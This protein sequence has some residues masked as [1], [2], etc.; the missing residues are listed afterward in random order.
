[1]I[2]G[3]LEGIVG[4]AC[5]CAAQKQATLRG[6]D[7]ATPANRLGHGEGGQ[8]LNPA[9]ACTITWNYPDGTRSLIPRYEFCEKCGLKP[10]TV[11]LTMRA[12]HK[13]IPT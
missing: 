2:F 4:C 8:I 9:L 7:P 1:M 10:I 5:P 6:V 13:I 11:S 3:Y 12:T